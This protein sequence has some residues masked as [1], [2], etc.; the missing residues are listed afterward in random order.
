MVSSA[1]NI[2]YGRFSCVNI[3]FA[4]LK[5]HAEKPGHGKLLFDE[6][7]YPRGYASNTKEPYVFEIDMQ[8]HKP[9]RH[10]GALRAKRRFCRCLL[11]IFLFRLIS[12]TMFFRFWYCSL[13]AHHILF[14][15]YKKYNESSPLYCPGTHGVNICE[16]TTGQNPN[17]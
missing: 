1:F 10:L 13:E 8:T 17:P 14:P 2:Q 15:D 12:L 6:T 3:S 11:L 5:V 7:L 4:D 9:T 16:M